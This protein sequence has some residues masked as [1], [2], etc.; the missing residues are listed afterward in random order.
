[1]ILKLHC[2]ENKGGWP[3]FPLIASILVFGLDVTGNSWPLK[4]GRAVTHCTR[5]P[6]LPLILGS[7]NP[8]LLFFQLFEASLK[9][10]FSKGICHI[11]LQIGTYFCLLLGSKLPWEQVTLSYSCYLLQ[12]HL[13]YFW[14][15]INV[16]VLKVLISFSWKQFSFVVIGNLL[17]L[18]NLPTQK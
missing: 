17:F 3:D 4:I 12:C 7:L 5:T 6:V 10:I 8:D 15:E 11:L 9:F 2:L 16:T 18:E 14:M 1:M 13:R